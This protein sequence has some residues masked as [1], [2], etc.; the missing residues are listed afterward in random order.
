MTLTKVGTPKKAA[1]DAVCAAIRERACSTGLIDQERCR[2]LATAAYAKRG[3]QL[4]KLAYCLSPIAAIARLQEYCPTIAVSPR[5]KLP[6]QSNPADATVLESVLNVIS[7]A[8]PKEWY[9]LG[10]EIDLSFHSEVL[11][12]LDSIPSDSKGWSSTQRRLESKVS[13]L[14]HLAHAVDER[15]EHEVTAESKAWLLYTQGACSLWAE[16]MEYVTL[17]AALATGLLQ[18]ASDEYLIAR[19]LLSECSWI[20]SFENLCL[21]CERPAEIH[22]LKS[23]GELRTT[24]TWRDGARCESV[25]S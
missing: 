18:S 24:V 3:L 9:G 20:Y 22:Q 17:D 12:A 7:A 14:T 5:P 2:A 1:I 8:Q 16:S 4:P 10:Q 6:L 11:D 13:E 15:L 21:I 25:F 23:R 19:Q